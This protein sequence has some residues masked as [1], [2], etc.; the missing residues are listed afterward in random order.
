[1]KATEQTMQVKKSKQVIKYLNKQEPAIRERIEF[2]FDNLPDGDVIPVASMPNTF[3]LRV[4]KF[5]ALF[6]YEN[7]I[8]KVTV[9]NVRG[10]VYKKG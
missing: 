8:I 1:M 6:V 4:G 10:Q 3:R 5:R 2:A 9:I 7:D